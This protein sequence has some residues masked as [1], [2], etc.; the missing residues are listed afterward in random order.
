M[1]ELRIAV[2]TC[3]A[4]PGA[5]DFDDTVGREIIDA[6]EERGWLVVAYHVCPGEME[7]ITTSILEMADMESADVVL[8]IGGTDLGPHDMAPEAT[9]R[10]CERL[11]P[12]LAEAIRSAARATDPG[13]ILSRATA[14]I[15]GSSLVVN[16]PGHGEPAHAS[17]GA[18]AGYLE[19]A[20]ARLHGTGA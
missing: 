1:S 9:E 5:G 20:A 8:T 6:C 14:G 3:A 19:Q 18:I 10:V 12:G 13:L 16:L 2:L 4:P 7:C 15:R 11:V 17:F